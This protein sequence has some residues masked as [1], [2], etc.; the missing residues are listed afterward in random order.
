MLELWDALFSEGSSLSLI[1]YFFVVML[2]QFRDKSEFTV[3]T[4]MYNYSIYYLHMYIYV[5][6]GG[7]NTYL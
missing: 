5:L 4:Y 1:D 7:G 2:M 3:H 6:K